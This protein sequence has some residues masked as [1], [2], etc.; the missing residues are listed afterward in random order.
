MV[1]NSYRKWYTS[2][3]G[4]ILY[5][6]LRSDPGTLTAAVQ[7]VCF[8]GR[9]DH[10]VSMASGAKPVIRLPDL[11]GHIAETPPPLGAVETLAMAAQAVRSAARRQFGSH[12]LFQ[13]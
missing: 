10:L 13:V 8:Q 3:H 12:G 2:V 7:T 11:N 6:G 4:E 9:C 1:Q 5:R